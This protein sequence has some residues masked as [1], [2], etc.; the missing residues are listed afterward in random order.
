[1]RLTYNQ[2]ALE[3]SRR[4]VDKLIKLVSANNKLVSFYLRDEVFS[5]V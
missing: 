3:L 1:M 5:P 2:P 4:S